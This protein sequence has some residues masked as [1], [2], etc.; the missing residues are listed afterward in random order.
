MQD[1]FRA[2]A[3][4]LKT[5]APTSRLSA[6]LP[7]GYGNADDDL[8]RW[9]ERPELRAIAQ[10]ETRGHMASDLGRYL[11]AS[12]FGAVHGYSPKADDYP[13]AMSPDHRNWHSGAFNDRFR[14]QLADQASTTVTS[15][16]SK[17]GH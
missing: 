3:R 7:E 14:V 17:D 15:H 10:H 6:R 1:A 5:E 4:R 12:V 9:V 2:I 16:I 8:L 11:F 13:L